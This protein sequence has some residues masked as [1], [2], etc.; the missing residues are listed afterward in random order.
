[1]AK[2]MTEQHDQE[3]SSTYVDIQCGL[4]SF[5]S[6]ESI[7]ANHLNTVHIEEIEMDVRPVLSCNQCNFTAPSSK[8]VSYHVKLEHEQFKC[9]HCEEVFVSTKKLSQHYMHYHQDWT[10]DCKD[11][12]FTTKH[13]TALARHRVSVH[14]KQ[15]NYTCGYTG[16]DRN[17]TRR[18]YL[19]LHSRKD[20][21]DEA[22]L[23]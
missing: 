6:S 16:C 1:M 5:K 9:D 4:C 14:D 8:A 11:C 7:F 19:V 2:H 20:H 13:R 15:R 21:C 18:E 3:K 10:F 12:G 22:L 17:F 23:D